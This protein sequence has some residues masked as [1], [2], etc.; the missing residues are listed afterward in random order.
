MNEL[1]RQQ[2]IAARLCQVEDRIE[3]AARRSGRRRDEI[4]LVVVT[5]TFPASDVGAAIEAGARII[6]E[7]RVQ[8]AESKR[9]AAGFEG[10]TWHL[11]G[12]LQSNKAR[13]AVALFDCIQSLSSAPLAVRL[14]RAVGE[15]GRAPFPVLI[16]VNLENEKTKSGVAPSG[17]LDLVQTVLALP[18]LTATGLMAVPPASEDPAAVRPFVRRLRELR[19]SIQATLGSKAD[20]LR[21][22]SIGMS[23]DF[24]SAIEEG[25]T[26]VRVGSAIFGQR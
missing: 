4:Q 8:E 2:E 19:D 9:T 11:I 20:S 1:D 24:D 5:K 7:N 18:H 17:A 14:D 10:V 26:I 16:E 23:H 25:A 15:L 3:S 22:L 13:R 21:D 6:G 12:P